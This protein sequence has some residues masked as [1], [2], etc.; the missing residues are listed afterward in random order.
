MAAWQGGCDQGCPD[1]DS[2]FSF[3]NCRCIHNQPPGNANRSHFLFSEPPASG[4]R[5]ALTGKRGILLRATL[6]G[7]AQVRPGLPQTRRHQTWGLQRSAVTFP[8][9]RGSSPCLSRPDRVPRFWVWFRLCPAS[10][11]GPDASSWAA[12]SVAGVGAGQG[13]E[14]AVEEKEAQERPV[15]KNPELWLVGRDPRAG[16]MW[17]DPVQ[18]ERK[19]MEAPQAGFGCGKFAQLLSRSGKWPPGTHL[20]AVSGYSHQSPHFS[21]EEN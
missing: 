4:R 9:P 14:N 2:D 20:E 13:Q 11:Q 3:V 5:L 6:Q 8:Q 1:T 10:L 21:N 17:K 16:E 19:K 15:H 7:P 12:R 18:S